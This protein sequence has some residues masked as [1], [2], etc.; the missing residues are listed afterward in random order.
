MATFISANV[1]NQYPLLYIFSGLILSFYGR[2]RRHTCNYTLSIHPSFKFTFILYSVWP[3]TILWPHKIIRK[4][5]TDNT[6]QAS[7]GR[8]FPTVVYTTCWHFT[9]RTVSPLLAVKA[10]SSLKEFCLGFISQNNKLCPSFYY[11]RLLASR[12]VGSRKS[13]C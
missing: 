11:L 6:E 13:S 4:K 7:T 10:N 8:C 1:P 5:F 2:M 9:A 12:P 3:E